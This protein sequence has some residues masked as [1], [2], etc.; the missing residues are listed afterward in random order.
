MLRPSSFFLIYFATLAACTPA[1]FDY[2]A[3]SEGEREAYLEA[4]SLGVY[5][6]LTGSLPGGKGIS[7]NVRE[8]TYDTARRRVEIVVDTRFG[9]DETPAFGS[10]MRAETV[11]RKV[12]PEHYL[13]TPLEA[14]EVTIYVR[15]ALEGGGTMLA[16]SLNPTTC[17]RYR[18]G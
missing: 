12:C 18:D 6:G 2:D 9:D 16:A 3:A 1:P 8:R 10:D 13:G 7:W 11:L 14:N 5:D 17:G 15:F 4:T